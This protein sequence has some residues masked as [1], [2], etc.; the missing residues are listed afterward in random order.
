MDLMYFGYFYE[1]ESEKYE[2]EFKTEFAKKFPDGQLQNAQDE[3]KGYRQQVILPDNQ[4]DEY[5]CWLM[6]FG[7]FEMSL[8]LE[9]MCRTDPR[10]YKRYIELTKQK[11]PDNFKDSKKP[12]S[13]L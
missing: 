12:T 3:I 6:A 10:D 11:Y 2:A 5:F 7:W 13:Q 9:V 4:S 1:P 8:T